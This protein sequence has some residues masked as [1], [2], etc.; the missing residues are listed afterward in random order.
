MFAATWLGTTLNFA[1]VHP[2]SVQATL[3]ALVA[4]S[5]TPATVSL[6]FGVAVP[7][8]TTVQLPDS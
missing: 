7:V 2:V 3:S 1:P 4:N 5:T 6:A 8:S